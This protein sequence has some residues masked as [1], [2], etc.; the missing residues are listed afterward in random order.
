MCVVLWHMHRKMAGGEWLASAACLSCGISSTRSRLP[1]LSIVPFLS[2]FASL[3]I[4]LFG[5]VLLRSSALYYFLLLPSHIIDL[6]SSVVA[7]VVVVVPPN[8]VGI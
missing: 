6:C 2:F 8:L 3:F 5:F 7:V 1:M 4:F